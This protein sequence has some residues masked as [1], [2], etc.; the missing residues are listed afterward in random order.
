VNTHPAQASP[1]PPAVREGETRASDA[2]RDAAAG[3]LN[4]A[5]AEG[6]LTA[7][8]HDQRLSAAYAARSWQ[9]LHRLTADL[10][11]ASGAATEPMAPG[12][13]AGAD[14]CLLCVLLIV[15][16]PAGIAYWLLSRHRPPLPPAGKR[17]QAGLHAQDR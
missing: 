15:C 1:A 17:G 10:P 3:L 12:M 14:R 11:A 5:F 9:Q 2:D 16:P 6:R 4:E 8:E 13:P 7:G